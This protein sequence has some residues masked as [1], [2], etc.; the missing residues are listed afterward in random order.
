MVI[1]LENIVAYNKKI[2]DSELLK[3]NSNIVRI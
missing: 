3:N 2:N 1:I